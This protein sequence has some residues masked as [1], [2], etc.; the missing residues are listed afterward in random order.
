[1]LFRSKFQWERLENL[2]TLA[3][4]GQIGGS[5]TV[6]LSSTVADGA[7]L[8]LLDQ[9]LRQ[10]LLIAFTEDDRLHVDEVR[11]IVRLLGG[12]TSI[13]TRQ[14]VGETARNL[15]NLARDFLVGW[16]DRVLSD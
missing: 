8:V 3:S 12:N 10:Q 15:P 16:S 1:M 6:D 13:D 4:E 2:L 5:S 9:Q 14:L 11:R 7:R